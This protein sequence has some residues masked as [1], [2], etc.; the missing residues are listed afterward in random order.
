MQKPYGSLALLIALSLFAGLARAAAL[1]APPTPEMQRLI[2]QY[3]TP[4]SILTIFEDHGRLFADGP[5]LPHAPL[6]GHGAH[7]AAALPGGERIPVDVELHGD[8]A[9]VVKL[10]H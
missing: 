8:R 1:P 6:A 7:Y 4:Q 3:G 5:G 10:L 2:G 9:S